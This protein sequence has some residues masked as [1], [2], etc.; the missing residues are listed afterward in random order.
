MAVSV[1]V[2]VVVGV[3]VLVVEVAL[4]LLDGVELVVLAATAAVGHAARL[5]G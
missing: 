5:F 3:D 1:V 2:V 4:V